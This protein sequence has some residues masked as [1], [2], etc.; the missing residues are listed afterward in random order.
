MSFKILKDMSLDFKFAIFNLNHQTNPFQM[1]M[2]LLFY[3]HWHRFM[4]K[5]TITKIILFSTFLLTSSSLP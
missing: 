1:K 5:L 2:V 4:C 3:S